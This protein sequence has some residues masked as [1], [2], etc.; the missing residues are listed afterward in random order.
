MTDAEPV[1][2]GSDDIVAIGPWWQT[3]GQNLIDAVALAEPQLTRVPVLVGEAKW[4]KQANAAR[5]VRQ[6]AVKAS[7]L[8]PDVDSLGYIVCARN[9]VSQVPEAVTAITAADI[10][11]PA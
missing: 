1:Q 10:F 5:I 11:A 2:G 7:A 9:E 4:A 3:D 6:L 8:T